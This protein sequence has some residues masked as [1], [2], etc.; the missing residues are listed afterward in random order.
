MTLETL[1]PLMLP[2][3]CVSIIM[4]LFN[5]RQAKRDDAARE[6]E[7][8]RRRSEGVQLALMLASAKLSYANAMALKR[9]KPNGEVEEGIEQYK[10]A[11]AA[12]KAFER[13]L[14]TDNN[15]E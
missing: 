14:V 3:L 4:F 2:S 6:H 13:E 12:F 7:T 15:I 8:R 9:G 10:T 11:M 5:R 1:T